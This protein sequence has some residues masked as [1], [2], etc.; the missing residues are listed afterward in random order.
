MRTLSHLPAPLSSCLLGTLRKSAPDASVACLGVEVQISEG[1]HERQDEKRKWAIC[2]AGFELAIT[3]SA[4]AAFLPY[5]GQRQR[6]VYSLTRIV[7]ELER[8]TKYLLDRPVQGVRRPLGSSCT[9]S[10]TTV[11]QVNKRTY[12]EQWIL[13]WPTRPSIAFLCAANVV[14]PCCGLDPSGTSPSPC[15]S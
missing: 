7:R 1:L 9:S 15:M 8:A 5:M 13:S 3:Y 11:K 14:Y 10:N 6:F 12:L 2:M 4:A